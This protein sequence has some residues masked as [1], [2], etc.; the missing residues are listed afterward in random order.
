MNKLAKIVA[1]GDT[2][3]CS[4]CRALAKVLR[5]AAFVAWLKSNAVTVAWADKGTNVAAFNAAKKAYSLSGD[6]PQIVLCDIAGKRLAKF[7]AR[8]DTCGTAKALIAKI[9]AACP[10]CCDG[11]GDKKP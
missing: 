10:G 4:H 2:V 6:F 9:G 8:E 1:W 7:V 5:S 3:K 11:C